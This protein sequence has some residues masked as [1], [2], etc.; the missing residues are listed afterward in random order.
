MKKYGLFTFLASGVILT[1]IPC[2]SFAETV[3]EAIQNA[4]A[5]HPAVEVAK[6]Q[7]ESALED[8]KEQYA[9]LFPVI[10]ATATGGRMFAN[11]STTRGLVTS[12]GEAYSWL[13]EGDAS[14]TQP[15]FNGFQTYNRIDAAEAREGAAQHTLADARQGIALRAAQSYLNVLRAQE[16]LKKT[17]SYEGRIK[18]YM[19]RINTMV[20]SGA[21]D[22]AEAA[23]AKNIHAMLQNT[24]AEM[25]G[26]VQAALADYAEAT[27]A[28]P[29]GALA[30][31]ESLETVVA[32]KVD[33]A[34]TVALKTHP[35]VLSAQKQLEAE[36]DEIDAETGA[37]FP[38]L[39]GELSY[40]KRDQKEEI[41]GELIDSRAVVRMNWAF[42]TG[43]AQLSR[44]RKSKAERSQAIAKANQIQRQIERDIRRAHTEYQTASKQKTLNEE[45]VTI[46]KNLFETYER[47]FE[48]SR[49]RLLQLMQ[50]ENQ[51]FSTELE[52][53]NA[54]YRLLMAEYAAIASTGRLLSTLKID[55]PAAQDIVSA[56][57]FESLPDQSASIE[58]EEGV[59]PASIGHF[60]NP[61]TETI[62]A[63][64]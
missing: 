7:Q 1:L 6:A 27:G 63:E 54:E 30:K 22:E 60:E 47:Q 49:V 4:L 37:L 8:E 15:L 28:V 11:N 64:K 12:R 34:V 41:G 24:I 2:V 40:L 17:Q 13:W 43:G 23:Q 52:K 51:L 31:P 59:K 50:A 44:I 58:P 62:K 35:L 53:I 39:D 45:R 18:D 20:D 5:T 56:D 36:E 25:E 14:L 32:S 29:K 61:V 16:A 55:T 9:N 21:A 19:A 10:N 33:D 38:T 48:A 57:A 3:Q 26:Q 42:S 46:A